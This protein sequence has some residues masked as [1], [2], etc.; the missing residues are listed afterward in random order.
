MSTGI[1]SF[2]PRSCTSRFTSPLQTR[3][4]HTGRIPDIALHPLIRSRPTGASAAR[5]AIRFLQVP[6]YLLPSSLTPVA[7]S[8]TI[9]SPSELYGS[10][11][12]SM[13]FPLLW[14]EM[15]YP[16]PKL[17]GWVLRLRESFAGWLSVSLVL[18][19]LDLVW[20]YVPG[21]PDWEPQFEANCHWDYD[22]ARRCFTQFRRAW[23][24]SLPVL[25]GPGVSLCSPILSAPVVVILLLT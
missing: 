8:P 15:I 21:W 3:P 10:A 17:R 25:P 12:L 24:C 1:P 9:S 16:W 2:C 22:W 13:T 11:L 7:W 18:C 5:P 20:A 4:S 14:D 19:F 23:H 6:A